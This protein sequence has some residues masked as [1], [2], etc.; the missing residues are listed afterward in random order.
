MKKKP[1]L[2]FLFDY[3]L[4]F[5]FKMGEEI[6]CVVDVICM[7]VKIVSERVRCIMVLLLVLHGVG[8]S[9]SR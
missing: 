4:F 9:G 7:C 8:G 2:L 6:N 3:S 1:L 5:Y